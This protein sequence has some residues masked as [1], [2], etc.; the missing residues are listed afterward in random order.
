MP[1]YHIAGVNQSGPDRL[2]AAAVDGLAQK[3]AKNRMQN[4]NETKRKG[5]TFQNNN[6]H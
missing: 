1:I 2:V 3:L 4:T 5:K 6:I